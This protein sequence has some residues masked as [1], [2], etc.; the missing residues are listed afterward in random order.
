MA[1]EYFDP[2]CFGL[3]DGEIEILGITGGTAPFKYQL[4]G[5]APSGND[6]F[7]NLA[8]GTYTVR[9]TDAND[10]YTERS[11]LLLEPSE[12]ILSLTGDTTIFC[13]DSLVLEASTNVDPSR[14]TGLEWFVNLLPNPIAVTDSSYNLLVKPAF[15]TTYKV[16]AFDENGCEATALTKILVD[17]QLPLY[18]PNAFDP[19]STI[20]NH[21]FKIFGNDHVK[22][23]RVFRV[24][25]RGGDMIVE[26]E[27]KM[28]NDADFGWDGTFNGKRCL[29]GV[30]VFMAEVNV[31]GRTKLV[32][33]TV[34]LVR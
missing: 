13:G 1:S 34:T 30:Y 14:I 3:K 9:I 8:P 10:C 2:T 22:I 7:R 6:R 31:D 24:F 5:S 19:D 11:F 28:L 23:V 27:D 29:P 12:I 16:V 26:Q 25:D 17:D 21:F 20:G 18:I 32:E 33:G 4:N 15:S